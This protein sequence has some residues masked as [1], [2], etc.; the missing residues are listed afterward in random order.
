MF[1][2]EL[3][4]YV[5]QIILQYTPSFNKVCY[6]SRLQGCFLLIYKTK[7]HASA[8]GYVAHLCARRFFY[9]PPTLRRR[10]TIEIGVVRPCGP[11]WFPDDILWMKSQIEARCGIYYKCILWIS[12][13][14]LIM[15]IFRQFLL[16]L[17]PFLCL[18][19]AKYL[20]S[21]W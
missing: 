4:L 9:C 2:V 18:K 16:E 14:S 3:F 1:K 17:C 13:S 10:G 12:R 6:T 21:R 11:N 5:I 20:V 7:Y 15:T 8:G 19:I